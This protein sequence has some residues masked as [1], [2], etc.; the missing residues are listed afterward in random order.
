MRSTWRKKWIL[1]IAGMVILVGTFGP[2]LAGVAV[3]VV[4][5]L[6]GQPEYMVYGELMPDEAAWKAR[7]ERRFAVRVRRVAGCNTS[8]TLMNYA[9]AYNWTVQRIIPVGGG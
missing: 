6:R 1:V 4:D 8:R 9:D 3:A 2:S 5:L 7:I